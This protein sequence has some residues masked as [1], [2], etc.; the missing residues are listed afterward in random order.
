MMEDGAKLQ[1]ITDMGVTS[2]PEEVPKS[3][4]TVR[5]LSAHRAKH[6]GLVEKDSNG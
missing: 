1:G 6:A 5:E 3:P 4:A 2:W